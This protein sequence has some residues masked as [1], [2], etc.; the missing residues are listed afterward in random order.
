MPALV[1]RTSPARS[2]RRCETICASA[3]FSL[4]VG[5]KYWLIRMAA[6]C[7]EQPLQRQTEPILAGFAQVDARTLRQ[8]TG[9]TANARATVQTEREQ[10]NGTDR[11]R[12]GGHHLPPHGLH[13]LRGPPD[14]SRGQEA[15]R[16]GVVVP[17]PGRPH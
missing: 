4:S 5:R 17:L 10:D 11:D 12:G 8:S 14:T 2:I 16:I 6:D 15:R 13:Y 7:R 9:E 1:C 3:G